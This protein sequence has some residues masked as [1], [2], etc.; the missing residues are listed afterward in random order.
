[1]K[2]FEFGIG[3]WDKKNINKYKVTDCQ[4]EILHLMCATNEMYWK[5]Q[6]YLE[7]RGGIRNLKIEPQPNWQMQ[8]KQ[9]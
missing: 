7:N 6:G 3:T 1:M 9:Y 2:H 4:K 8:N 5:F